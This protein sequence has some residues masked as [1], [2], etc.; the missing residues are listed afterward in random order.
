MEH[1]KPVHRPFALMLK[2]IAMGIAEVI[3]G[4]S[5]GTI[6]FI[7]SIYER[8]LAAIKR[9]D[10][11]FLKLILR[12][13]FSD[14]WKMLDRIFLLWLFG[15]MGCGVVSGV[16]GVSHLMTHYPEILWAFFFGLIA[17]SAWYIGRQ[18]Q[19]WNAGRILLLLLG[20]AIAYVITQV[21]PAH[22]N[23]QLWYVALSG[24]LAISALMLPGISGSFILLLLGMYPIVI[25]AVKSVLTSPGGTE[26]ILLTCFALGMLIGV[27]AFSRVLT[28]MFRHYHASTLALLAGFMVGSLGKIWPWRIPVRWIESTGN[29]KTTGVM[30]EGARVVSEQVV[31]PGSYPYEP[32]T[33]AVVLALLAGVAIILLTMYFES[34]CKS[35]SISSQA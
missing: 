21:S 35:T 25:G 19:G 20:I 28:W 10:I 15:G 11:E 31:L 3:P 26:I 29:M 12:G 1:P 6:A 27:I 14:A 32:H 8:L 7:T 18:V 17:A 33:I 22:G 13:R 4:V 16:F 5:G 2:G 9:V 30:E 23:T 34:R 24:F